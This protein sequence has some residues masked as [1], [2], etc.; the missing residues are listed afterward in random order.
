[1]R[2]LGVNAVFRDPAALIFDGE[3]SQQ[4]RR[5]GSHAENTARVPFP[6][7]R[8]RSFASVSSMA[9]WNPRNWT[10][11]RTPMTRHSQPGPHTPGEIAAMS[12]TSI[13]FPPVAVF[14]RLA[15]E[16]RVR[17]LARGR[18][19]AV[20]FDRDGTLIEDVPY[21]GDPRV[22][23]PMPGAAAALDRVRRAGLRMAIIS[24][25]SAI[26]RGLISASAAN[27]VNRRV[28]QLLGPIGPWLVCPHPPELN[29]VCRKPR[30]GLVKQAA[31]ALGVGAGECVVIGD[32]GA[33]IEAAQA[34]GARAVLVP[35][36]STRREEVAAA[37]QIAPTLSAAV[38]IVLGARRW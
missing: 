28:E 23:V 3:R 4:P 14:H 32:I 24:N 22:V 26:G 18:P 31:A 9:A 21:N 1:M 20:L 34:A 30:P 15:G 13:A 35:T 2:V 38:D 19:K 16:L 17:L 27:S 25:Q 10:W 33:D 29:C 12:A 7:R 11:S 6:S 36:Q 8:G 37:P 5:S